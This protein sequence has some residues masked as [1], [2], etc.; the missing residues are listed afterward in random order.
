MSTKSKAIILT[1]L[2]MVLGG[3][4]VVLSG[5]A[6]VLHPEWWGRL[7]ALASFSM[8][9]FAFGKSNGRDK[10]K[11]EHAEID[12]LA[13]VMASLK[14]FDNRFTAGQIKPK[15]VVSV[16]ISSALMAVWFTLWFTPLVAVIVAAGLFVLT[17]I[18]RA[19]LG[20][21]YPELAK[22]SVKRSMEK[23]IKDVRGRPGRPPF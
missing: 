2:A 8:A 20:K 23:A 1:V 11:A 14:H 9:V 10:A 12:P 16:A 22:M 13:P 19:A 7:A 15:D 17:L 6:T 18:M 21:L 5:W 3:S 4:E